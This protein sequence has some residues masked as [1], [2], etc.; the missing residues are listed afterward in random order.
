MVRRRKVLIGIGTSVAL[1]GCSGDTNN[2]QPEENQE[3]EPEE[4]TEEEPEEESQSET[5]AVFEVVETVDETNFLSTDEISVGGVVEN[6]GGS[7]GE[8][9]VEIQDP[10]GNTVASEEVELESGETYN[11]VINIE[12]GTFQAGEYEIII[13]TEDDEV[14]YT[15]TV[16]EPQEETGDSGYQVRV[17]YDGEWSGSISGDGSSRSVD[18][19]GTE[20]FDVDGDPFIVSANAQKEDDS[21]DELVIEILED[22]EVIASKR[23]SAEYGVA[24]VT[25]EDGIDEGGDSDST[26]DSGDSDSTDDSGDSDSTDD[27]GDSGS[28]YEVRI[29]YDGEWSGAVGS[30]GS[31]S[32]VDGS[33]T[34]TIEIDGDPDIISANAQKQEAN[35]DEL[36]VQILK[37]GEVVKESSTTA[38]YGVAQVS[39][40]NY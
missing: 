16:S 29:E 5:E 19:S 14:S 30:G 8:Q 39:Y 32:S 7:V 13:L 11:A 4:E 1:A 26:D 2:D 12:P 3:S 40:S 9:T 33:G 22:G 31:A 23:T 15:I 35:S 27:S 36:V 24:Q 20:T 17:R 28:S 25:S 38:E 6:T 37:D 34:E 18:G 10:A 21:S